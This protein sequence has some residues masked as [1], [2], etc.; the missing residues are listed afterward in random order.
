MLRR[1]LI[2]ISIW[3]AIALTLSACSSSSDFPDLA[4]TTWKLKSY[5]TAKDQIPAAEGVNTSLV[6]GTDGKVSGNLGCNGFGGDYSQ[7]E[8]HLTFS[9]MMSTM[10]A[11]MEPQMS[12][13]T[14]A[15]ST[16][17]GAVKFTIQG[18]DLTLV[19]ADGGSQIILEKP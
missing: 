10:M 5:G 19:A 8:D 2:V 7:E 9:Q 6:F 1:I 18:N 17:N 13:E 15:L 14:T 11:C 3:L 12:Q 16:L 4:G